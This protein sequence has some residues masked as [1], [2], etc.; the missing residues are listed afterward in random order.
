KF[1]RAH[2]HI[3]ALAELRGNWDILEAEGTIERPRRILGCI[4]K[5]Y[6]QEVKARQLVE[7]SPLP[8]CF[9]QGRN[10]L[11]GGLCM[12][13]DPGVVAGPALEGAREGT[14][15]VA[16]EFDTQGIVLPEE[17]PRCRGCECGRGM[18]ELD[19]RLRGLWVDQHLP[20]DHLEDNRR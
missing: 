13:D 17:P 18:R 11:S 14:C 1:L 5:L 2:A 20:D 16:V 15:Q 12:K 6:G 7:A 19:E 9:Q 3:L 4:L 8:Q 10:R